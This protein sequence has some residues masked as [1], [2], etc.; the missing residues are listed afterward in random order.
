[1]PAG[2]HHVALSYVDGRQHNYS[3]FSSACVISDY[4][5]GEDVSD[6]DIAF[7]FADREVSCCIFR[8]ISE[9]MPM[10]CFHHVLILLTGYL[11]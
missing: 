5:K 6:L 10:G 9:R 1:M 8:L 4:M 3:F 2:N 11:S 7:W